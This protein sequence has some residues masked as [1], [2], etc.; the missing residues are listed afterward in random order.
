MLLPEDWE[1]LQFTRNPKVG[2]CAFFDRHALRLEVSWRQADST[3]DMKRLLSD[4]R[5]SLQEQ[6]AEILGPRHVGAWDGIESV[7]DGALSTRFG[8]FFPGESCLVEFIFFWPDAITDAALQGR[9]LQSVREQDPALSDSDLR[10]WRAFG[11]D[12]L[13]PPGLTLTECEVRPAHAE[14]TFSDAQTGIGVRCARRGMLVEW[15]SGALG[16]WLQGWVAA[17]V[18]IT[19]VRST[20]HRRHR[21]EQLTGTRRAPGLRGALGKKLKC[22]AAAW[23]CPNDERLYSVSLTSPMRSAPGK[24]CETQLSCCTDMELRL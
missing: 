18:E 1:M 24:V 11:M 22:N 20:E 10:R 16:P 4:T 19:S 14:M 13:V 8:R 2:R 9:V 12:F 3:P 17:A 5:A 23:V 6:D 21:V 7:V 15:F